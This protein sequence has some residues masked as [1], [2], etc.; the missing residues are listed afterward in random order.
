MGRSV[1]AGPFTDNAAQSITDSVLQVGEYPPYRRNTDDKFA[2]TITAS[3]RAR[4]DPCTHT[5]DDHRSYRWLV[6]PI[7]SGVTSH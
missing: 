5:G 1:C 6:T 2:L 3:A 7:T 4:R